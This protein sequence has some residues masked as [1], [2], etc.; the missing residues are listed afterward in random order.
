VTARAGAVPTSLPWALA[1]MT[2]LQALVALGVFAVAVT[3]PMLGLPLV[4]VGLYQSAIFAVGAATSLSSGWLCARFGPVRVAQGC[5]LAVAAAACVLAIGA[6][7]AAPGAAPPVAA[8]A[9]AAVLFGLAF[10]PETPA[11]A[12]ILGPLAPPGRRT[13]VFS[14]RQ[15]GN[16]IGAVAGS[17]LLPL[18]TAAAGIGWAC[19]AIVAAGLLLALAYGRLRAVPALRAPAG[20]A[21]QR[22]S[23]R[24]ALRSMWAC[25]PLRRLV[26]MALAFSAMQATLNGFLASHAARHWEIDP[27]RAGWL[28]ATAQAGGLVGRLLWGWLATRSGSAVAWLFGLGLGMTA[29]AVGVAAVPAGMPGVAL[30]VLAF[31]FGLTASG[32]NGVFLAEVARLSPGREAAH[33]GALLMLSYAG[34]VVGPLLH[35][36]LSTRVAPGAGYAAMAAACAL[37]C[38]AL[39]PRDTDADAGSGR[40][41]A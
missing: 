28:L 40:R 26:P 1:A 2:G 32:W 35:A 34:L 41:S 8:L 6:G 22:A 13:L 23:P 25:A 10:G 33:T 3:A 15:T 14:I 29:C 21:P 16:Q 12:A 20:A 17:L 31:A 19:G 27:I 39:W 4:V 30:G 7:S 5:A 11:S 9:I 38:I 18:L 24:A 36:G 37:A